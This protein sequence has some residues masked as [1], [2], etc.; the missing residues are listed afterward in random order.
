[1][2][3]CGKTRPKLGLYRLSA[4]GDANASVS[5]LVEAEIRAWIECKRCGRIDK[6]SFPVRIPEE[7]AFSETEK[8]CATCE[9][10]N[11]YAHMYL[12]RVVRHVH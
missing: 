6:P 11:G 10:C 12:E 7:V 3:V 1:M 4:A 9:R 8:V 2:H 5:A